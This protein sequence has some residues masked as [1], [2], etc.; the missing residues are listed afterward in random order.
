VP[1]VDSHCH[2]SLSWYEP[3]E[4]LLFQME[5]NGV[6]HAVLI[7]MQ[8]QYDNSYQ[9]ECAHRFPGKFAPVVIVDPSRPDAPDALRREA[10]QGASGVRLRPADPPGLWQAAS[11]LGLSI[12]CG[13]GSQAFAS[14]EFA[15]LVESVDVPVVVEHLGGLKGPDDDQQQ[16][17]R[18]RI[19]GL[20]RFPHAHIKMHG[21]GEFQ[22][23]AMPATEPSPFVQPISSLLEAACEAFGAS[24]VMWGSDYPP[25][26][27]REGYRNALRTTMERLATKSEADRGEIFGGTA[28]KVFPIR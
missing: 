20:A 15:R 6:D 11:K 19:F 3:V 10:D 27:G 28:L 22:P 18:R 4:V 7:Q 13:G 21:L 1:I 26:S 2:V 14:D 23:R 8:G 5:R 16:A 24:R 17:L 9:R 12:S 25:V